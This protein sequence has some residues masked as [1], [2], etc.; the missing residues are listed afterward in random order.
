MH[1]PETDIFPPLER[2]R[3]HS[4]SRQPKCHPQIPLSVS[5]PIPL[6]GSHLPSPQSIVTTT[7]LQ[8]KTLSHMHCPQI[9]C[10]TWL[11]PAVF[12]FHLSFRFGGFVL[13]CRVLSCFG[14]FAFGVVFLFFACFVVTSWR[15]TEVCTGPL[16]VHSWGRSICRRPRVCVNYQIKPFCMQLNV[17][18]DLAEAMKALDGKNQFPF[19]FPPRLRPAV[20][21]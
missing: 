19:E 3:L 17:L 9:C 13:C 4:V 14:G 8:R 1:G 18:N 11:K 5:L 10:I 6:F 20:S 21:M 12:N 2:D 7:L 16:P 15:P